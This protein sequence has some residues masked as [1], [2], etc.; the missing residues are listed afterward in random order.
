MLDKPGLT[1]EQE[2]AIA[3]L[4]ISHADEYAIPE[5][6]DLSSRLTSDSSTFDIDEDIQKPL[7]ITAFLVLFL[8]ALLVNPAYGLN[9]DLYRTEDLPDLIDHEACDPNGDITT[10]GGACKSA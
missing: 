8:A 7:E 5:V 3:P 2:E 9:T 10:P 6:D 4:K 1:P